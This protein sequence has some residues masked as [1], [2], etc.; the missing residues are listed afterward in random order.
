M[1]ERRATAPAGRGYPGPL[2]AGLSGRGA[3]VGGAG[4]VADVWSLLAHDARSGRPLLPPRPLGTGLAGALL[5]ELMLARCIGLRSDIAV[6]I[7]RNVSG[8][9]VA[10]HV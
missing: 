7:G 1:H 10:G 8:A 2:D 4:L 3:G 5:A 6:V 9:A